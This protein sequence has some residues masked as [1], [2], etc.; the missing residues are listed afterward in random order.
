MPPEQRAGAPAQA[1]ADVHAFGATLREVLGHLTVEPPP[2]LLELSLACLR[3]D[4][5]RRPDV[6]TLIRHLA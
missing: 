2:E 5:A 4:P 6:Q 1:S 3:R